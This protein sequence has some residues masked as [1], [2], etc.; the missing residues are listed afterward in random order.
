ML[1]FSFH[2]NVSSSW[3]Q[4]TSIFS[5]EIWSLPHL[6]LQNNKSYKESTLQTWN[7]ISFFTQMILNY[8]LDILVIKADGWIEGIDKRFYHK[9]KI[10]YSVKGAMQQD[11]DDLIL[12]SPIIQYFW[13]KTFSSFWQ[14]RMPEYYIKTCK[15]II[16][17][18]KRKWYTISSSYVKKNNF[19]IWI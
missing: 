9:C 14:K 5:F 19:E 17:N 12:V 1:S 11:F 3:W 15:K 8:C 18:G 7:N 13:R 6:H 4:S 2:L 16:L 10:C